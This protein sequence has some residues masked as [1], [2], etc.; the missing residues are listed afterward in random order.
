VND[1]DDARLRG[2]I[3]EARRETNGGLCPVRYGAPENC[4]SN[5]AQPTRLEARK[6]PHGTESNRLRQ[7]TQSKPPFER[8]RFNGRRHEAMP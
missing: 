8:Y 5:S 3:G 7:W 1:F 6:E 4:Q 2:R